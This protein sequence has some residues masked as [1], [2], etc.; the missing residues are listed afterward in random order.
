MSKS[1]EI[2]E[3]IDTYD[4]D[5]R[6]FFLN[7]DLFL[8][9]YDLLNEEFIECK[10]II[11]NDVNEKLKEV[12]NAWNV[13]D[14]PKAYCDS[15]VSKYHREYIGIKGRFL[16][17]ILPNSI[18]IMLLMLLFLSSNGISQL[19]NLS[20]KGI[21]INIW[22]VML[23]I[24]AISNY[25]IPLISHNMNLFVRKPKFNIWFLFVYVL[26]FMF[27]YSFANSELI[28]SPLF[29]VHPLV[30]VILLFMLCIYFYTNRNKLYF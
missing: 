6:Q 12:D 17:R 8:R 19:F 9:N 25:I 3:I 26:Y 4:N 23:I 22:D 10:W 28:S 2:K 18:G 1:Q 16:K 30:L 29:F 11:V 21:E 27:L 7:V 15:V 24:L 13:Y 14:D 20:N 5:D